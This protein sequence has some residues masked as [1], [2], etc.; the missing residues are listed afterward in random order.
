MSENL[1]NWEPEPVKPAPI[2][3]KVSPYREDQK[4]LDRRKKAIPATSRRFECPGCGI[5]K[6]VEPTYS[7][8]EWHYFGQCSF[9]GAK[10]ANAYRLMVRCQEC[11]TKNAMTSRNPEGRCDCESEPARPF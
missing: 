2:T 9:C 3:L 4:A 1:E 7:G 11:G 8:E 10:W 5:A 6:H